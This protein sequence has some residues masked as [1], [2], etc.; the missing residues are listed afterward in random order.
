VEDPE[1]E[2][3]LAASTALEADSGEQGWNRNLAEE[4][5][6]WESVPQTR[7]EEVRKNF[8]ALYG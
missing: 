3:F 6:A 1:F 8:E 7:I 4:T 2:I 5:Q